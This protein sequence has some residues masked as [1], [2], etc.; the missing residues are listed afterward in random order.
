MAAKTKADFKKENIRL[1]TVKATYSRAHK[2]LEEKYEEIEALIK[3][4]EE[5]SQR[6]SEATAKIT[7]E[8]I[9][10]YRMQ[11][12]AALTK[13]DRGAEALID[14][15]LLLSDADTTEGVDVMTERAST[16]ISRL[17]KVPILP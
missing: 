16:D 1:G 7:S 5:D 6:W 15:I 12:E 13:M 2:H 9:Q 8:S 4:R 3:R 14:V 10:K 17:C 11:A